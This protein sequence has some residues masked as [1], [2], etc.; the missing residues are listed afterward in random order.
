MQRKHPIPHFP[1]IGAHMSIA[2]GTYNALL[3]GESAGC[4]TIQVFASSNTRWHAKIPDAGEVLRFRE[5]Q[6]RTAIAPVLAHNCYL[7]NLAS[8]D[9]IVYHKSI[10]RMKTEIEICDKLGLPY[11]VM[12]PGSHKGQGINGGI[13]QV[14]RAVNG[15][16]KGSR[17]HILYETTAGQ[18]TSIGFTFE[19][20]AELISLARD[21]SRVGVCYDTCH[22]F[23]A[24]YDFHTGRAYRETMRRF[25]NLV[26]LDKICAFH[27]NDSLRE[28][29]SRIDRHEHIGRGH[30]GE[31]AFRLILRD[32]RF[33]DV[34]KILE[35]P[36]GRGMYWDRRNLALLRRLA[37]CPPHSR[38]E[39]AEKKT[40]HS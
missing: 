34:P 32:E 5:E 37:G 10:A 18:G 3:D 24:G 39:N 16:M 31:G 1:L 9:E 15:L 35:T 22:A 12:H 36:K 13:R 19:Q 8:P 25:D 14:A 20:M 33:R 23:A 27:F 4:A 28:L 17:V 6:Q 38:P 21:G 2:G 7:I 26:G 11:L 30:L 40:R 29:G